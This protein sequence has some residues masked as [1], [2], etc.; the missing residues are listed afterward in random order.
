MWEKA[1]GIL[2]AKCEVSHTGTHHQFEKFK[3][4]VRTIGRYPK[5]VFVG[6]F[7]NDIAND[8]AFP[9]STVVEGFLV[10]TVFTTEPK[11]LTRISN[12]ELFPVVSQ[13][14]KTFE[15]YR[16]KKLLAPPPVWAAIKVFL[17]RHSLLINI[18]NTARKMMLSDNS[19]SDKSPAEQNRVGSKFGRS[20]NRVFN[21]PDIRTKFS[22]SPLAEPTKQAIKAWGDHGESHGYQLV[23]LLIPPR[24]NQKIDFVDFALLFQERGWSQEELYWQKDQH[25]NNEGN[26]HVGRELSQLRY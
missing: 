7:P 12:E 11:Q 23:F 3:R 10:E 16:L 14:I 26:R 21:D 18:L 4:V 19:D 8:L 5:V 1:P 13:Q 2:A 6:F 20:I 24:I 9:H 17:L 25:L 15:D 22:H